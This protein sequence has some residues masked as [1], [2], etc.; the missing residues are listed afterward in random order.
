MLKSLVAMLSLCAVA[1]VAN[2]G[3]T[4]AQAAPAAP[5]IGACRWTCGGNPTRFTS[6]AACQA[7][8][9]TECDVVC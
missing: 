2:I 8:C 6:E 9:S 5:S 4:P 7:V 1:A 3:T